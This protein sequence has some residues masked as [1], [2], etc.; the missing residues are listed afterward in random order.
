M[1]GHE[2][3]GVL[4]ERAHQPLLGEAR[5]RRRLD[6]NRIDPGRDRRRRAKPASEPVLD[7]AQITRAAFLGER[8]ERGGARCRGHHDDPVRDRRP[9]RRLD[10]GV[11]EPFEPTGLR[12]D[13]GRRDHKRGALRDLAPIGSFRRARR[14]AAIRRQDKDPAVA[15]PTRGQNRAPDKA[16]PQ[17]LALA[18]RL[19]HAADNIART[20]D[21]RKQDQDRRWGH[22]SSRIHTLDG[23]DHLRRRSTPTRR[24][25]LI[26]D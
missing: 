1:P 10:A 3:V 16:E 7:R 6:D 24:R 4:D 15:G 23:I 26:D 5:I 11:L 12:Q 8:I 18:L 19:P 21:G 25:L 2:A 9:R 13:R 20:G 17:N 14:G 22:D